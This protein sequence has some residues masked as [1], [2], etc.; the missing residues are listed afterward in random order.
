M[1]YNLLFLVLIYFGIATQLS[2]AME[3]SLI[4]DT[5]KKID[6]NGVYC[7]HY[8]ENNNTLFML[9]EQGCYISNIKEQENKKISDIGFYGWYD[10]PFLYRNMHVSRDGKKV[11]IANKE[12]TIEIIDSIDKKKKS[13]QE[14]FPVQFVCFDSNDHVIAFVKERQ[15]Y[16]S[17]RKYTYNEKGFLPHISEVSERIRTDCPAKFNFAINKSMLCVIDNRLT[18]KL[19]DLFN[20]KFKN[21]YD[22][23][24]VADLNLHSL[25]HNIP[26]Q[27]NDEFVA[28]VATDNRNIKPICRL[29]LIFKIIDQYALSLQRSIGCRQGS[30]RNTLFYPTTSIIVTTS[31]PR[32]NLKKYIQYWDI[33]TGKCLHEFLIDDGTRNSAYSLGIILSMS[34]APTGE[35]IAITTGY[36]ECTIY[37]VPVHIA[38]KHAKSDLVLRSFLLKELCEQYKEK[39]GPI[40]REIRA[41]I[42]FLC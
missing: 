21:A 28:L 12:S 2:C 35:N 19:Y 10:G 22:W 27:M 33:V 29:L 23:T 8:G 36:S 41:I 4:V 14:A 24:L 11:V 9:T 16:G 18:V 13:W 20:F 26:C 31:Q 25:E 7:A 42:C 1:K 30:F 32:E 17:L 34:F 37:K 5:I 3:P 38:Y 15:D 39:C 40:P 6:G